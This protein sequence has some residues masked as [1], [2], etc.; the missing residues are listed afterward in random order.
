MSSSPRPLNVLGEPLA[1]CGTDPVTGFYRNGFCWTSPEDVGRHTICAV[2]TAE[3]LD[4]Q[5]RTGNDLV[6][7]MPAYRFPGLKPGDTWC[8]VAVR[9]LHA[10]RDGAAAP[11]VLAATH[12]ATL[13]V[14]PLEILRR[15]A[16]DVPDD[17]SSLGSE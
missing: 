14:V 9:W 4:H 8:V 5:V 3:F 12:E 10:H 6:T 7:P 16:V 13:H 1:E 2:M 11:V 15:Y 17:A